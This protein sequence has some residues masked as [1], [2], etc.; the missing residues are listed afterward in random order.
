VN[1][2]NYEEYVLGGSI[3][4]GY[5]QLDLEKIRE[6]DLILKSPFPH[7]R[8]A[9]EAMNDL[10]SIPQE[11]YKASLLVLPTGGGKT[12]T[13]INWIS[14]IMLSRNIKVLWMAQSSY[15]LDQATQGFVQEASNIM[16]DRRTLNI[17]TVSSS[18]AHAGSGYIETSDDVVIITTQTATSDILN[19]T[20]GF[21]GESVKY[22]LRKWVEASK[23]D[24]L[25]VVLD[26]AHHAP[27]YGCRSLLLE[28]KGIVPNLYLLGLTATPTHNDK[29]I[30]GWL[31][32]IFS[33]GVCYQADINNLYKSN[34]LAKPEYI[35]KPTGRE[36]SVDDK[37]YNRIM[38]L[39][40]DLPN[41]IVEDLAKDSARNDLIISDYIINKKK[42]GKTIIFAD[43]W[44]QCEYIVEKL[45]E[46]NISADSIYSSVSGNRQSSM[47]GQGRRDNTYNEK[48]LKDFKENK[49]DVLVN[50]KML[51]EGVDVPDVQTV[52]I[53]R[54]TTSGILLTQMI[55]RSLRGPKAGGG[56]S[57]TQANIVFFMDK[58]SRLLPFA[59]IVNLEGGTA[60]DRVIRPGVPPMELISIMLVKRACRDIEFQGKENYSSRHFVPVGWFETEYTVAVEQEDDSDNNQ[61]LASL[62]SSVMVYES[63]VASVLHLVKE[64][65][66]MQNSSKIPK[67]WAKENCDINTL[68]EEF[69][70]KNPK[71]I[72]FDEDIDGNLGS[73]VSHIIR[74]I[75][76]NATEPEFVKFEVREQYDIDRLAVDNSN[77]TRAMEREVLKREY[78]DPRK[79]WR[80]L[81]K[82]YQWF[83]D[84][85]NQVW[86]RMDAKPD[87]LP[88]VIIKEVTK[89]LPEDYRDSLMTRDL[90]RCRCCGREFG[91]GLRLEIDHILPVKL[92]G[93]TELDNLQLL[94]KSCN[95]EKGTEL[96]NFLNTSIDLASKPEFRLIT[97]TAKEPVECTIKRIINFFFRAA[98]VSDVKY[99]ERR[100]GRYYSKWIIEIHRD[101]HVE[102]LRD[103]EMALLR[104]IKNDLGYNQVKD[105]EVKKV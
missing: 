78:N 31:D 11:G 12:Y 8:A 22:K 25:F 80:T 77:L 37:L 74:H 19:E 39:H 62:H 89:H 101:N 95:R 3:M 34:I 28:L 21:R 103:H 93:R 83:V 6:Q 88:E 65:M 40:K 76:Q 56:K 41:N 81:Y 94:C 29:R 85:Y 63:N 99:H 79:M 45:K 96:I 92:G 53:T 46:K 86:E 102:L 13:A 20:I 61:E 14:R 32:K 100:N 7:Q 44:Y 59:N 38:N 5:H 60:T 104:F 9:F 50:V 55:G 18:R 90:K 35:Q 1:V 24:G 16:P 84:A 67:H 43:R 48:V 64:L 10:Y 23:E 30:S 69:I 91:K 52:M 66:V 72:N 51:T 54:N 4:N 26:E 17:R 49:L 36:M 68:I 42:Y 87:G 75:A 33:N 27:A 70:S 73:G 57:K 97:T 71:L 98:A 15:L 82:R 105:I 47:D 58:W 2:I